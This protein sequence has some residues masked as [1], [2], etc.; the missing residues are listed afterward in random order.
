MQGRMTKKA[1]DWFSR[2]YPD[3]SPPS[4]VQKLYDADYN[5]CAELYQQDARLAATVAGWTTGMGATFIFCRLAD[6]VALPAIG[7]PVGTI[8]EA[9][10]LT[11]GV[12][13]GV[14]GAKLAKHIVIERKMG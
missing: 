6:A 4:Y 7:T 3:R 13:A 2:R 12:G 11:G 5:H 9:A 10:I 14:G 1:N 8:I